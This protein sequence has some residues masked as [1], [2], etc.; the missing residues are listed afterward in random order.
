LR[1]TKGKVTKE[2]LIKEVDEESED[3]DTDEQFQFKR[4]TSERFAITALDI[5][6]LIAL[7][8]EVN[9]IHLCIVGKICFPVCTL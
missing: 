9:V 3:M 5:G 4:A 2:H 8:I 6:E 1:G 7:D